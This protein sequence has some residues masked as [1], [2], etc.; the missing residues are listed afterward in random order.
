MMFNDVLRKGD[1]S[2]VARMG[3]FLMSVDIYSNNPL[4]S[5]RKSAKMSLGAL[6]APHPRGRRK[7]APIAY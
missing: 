1:I 6:A 3:T 4:R 5:L 2:N 7:Y